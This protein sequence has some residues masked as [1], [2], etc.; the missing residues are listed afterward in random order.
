M[1]ID[2]DGVRQRMKASGRMFA[3][4]ARS[5]GIDAQHFQHMLCG[6]IQPFPEDIAALERDGLL[7]WKEENDQAA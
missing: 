7:V 5:K 4:Y 6:R 3:P 2:F 1:K